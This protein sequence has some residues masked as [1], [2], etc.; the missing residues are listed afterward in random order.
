M[1]KLI[2]ISGKIGAGK[3]LTG[4]MLMQSGSADGYLFR[5][6][7]FADTLKAC[8]A[9]I[10]NCDVSKFEDHTFK[11]TPLGGNW[12]RL[13][14]REFLQKFGTEVGRQIHPDVWVNSLFEGLGPYDHRIITDVRFPNEADAIKRNGGVNI[15]VIRDIGTTGDI[16]T[17]ASETALDDYPFD[18]II[19]N[20]GTIEELTLKIKD[21][22]TKIR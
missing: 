5:I 2:G 7:K 17:H 22:W 18:Y 19:D 13:T 15:R 3:D 4:A 10:L 1:G 14:P 16:A 9:L 11:S 6:K 8:A 21:L 20:S 12:G